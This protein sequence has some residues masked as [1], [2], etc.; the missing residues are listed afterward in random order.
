MSVTYAYDVK[1]SGDHVVA[2]ADELLT[3]A[4]ESMLPGALLVNDLPACWW[5]NFVWIVLTH[6]IVQCLP[7]WFPG[8]GFKRRAQYGRKL[9]HEMVNAPFNMVKED[10]VTFATQLLTYDV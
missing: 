1:E 3:L 7:D 10:L 9:S 2:I 5:S 8:T 4:S 6:S